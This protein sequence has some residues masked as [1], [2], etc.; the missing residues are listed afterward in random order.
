MSYEG[1]YFV[2]SR[3]PDV[4]YEQFEQLP[5]TIGLALNKRQITSS[6]LAI[7]KYNAEGKR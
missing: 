2:F 1:C 6:H 4:L 7:V 3:L 5:R